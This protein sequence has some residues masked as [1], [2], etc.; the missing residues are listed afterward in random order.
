MK[1][2]SEV[3]ADAR[4]M[5]SKLQ[6]K[7]F[8]AVLTRA[9]A[10]KLLSPDSPGGETPIVTDGVSMAPVSSEN[11]RKLTSTETKET[12]TLW[13][14]TLIDQVDPT[15][16]SSKACQPFTAL[17]G[18]PR[19]LWSDQG[20]NFVGAKPVLQELYEFLSSINKDQVQKK[21]AAVGT[22]WMWV[23]HPADSPH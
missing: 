9:Q 7:A 11:G 14:A 18:H 2:A 21:A 12:E 13:G 1:S 16:C 20:T 3:A 6:R 5:V 19:K 22:D 4:E 15:R 10:K 23:F 8:S 17:R